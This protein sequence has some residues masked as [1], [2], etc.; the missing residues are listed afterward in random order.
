MVAHG[1]LYHVARVEVHHG[2]DVKL[3]CHDFAEVFWVEKGNGSHFIN[4]Q[5][6]PLQRGDLV[7]MRPDD[8]HHFGIQAD[9]EGA[10]VM[11]NL[12]FPTTTLDF[13]KE[14]YF[15]EAPDWPWAGDELPTQYKISGSVVESLA[16]GVEN[17]SMTHQ[18]RLELEAFLAGLLLQ[19][20]RPPMQWLGGGAEERLDNQPLPVWMENALVAFSE[21]RYLEQGTPALADLAGRC[22]EHVNRVLR[23]HTGR[24]A[25][26]IVSELRL[27]FAARQLRLTNRALLDIAGD[28]GISSPSHFHRLFRERFGTSPRRYRLQQ[29]SVARPPRG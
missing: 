1:G 20:S 9:G 17:M 19:L 12:A 15:S 23:R 4:G 26:E 25:T 28:C 10:L 2:Y 24:S 27:E 16:A 11:V 8:G 22:P 13:L 5:T 18:N 3:H 21:P 14:R 7:L 6:L 29:Q